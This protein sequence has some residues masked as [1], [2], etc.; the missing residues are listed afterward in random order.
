MNTHRPSRT[1]T[2]CL[3]VSLL[4]ILLLGCRDGDGGDTAAWEIATVATEG[5]VGEYCSVAVDGEGNA[6]VVYFDHTEDEQ[7]GTDTVPYGN[8][9]YASDVGGAWEAVTLDTGTGLTP[10]VIVGDD[11]VVHVVHT[12]LGVSDL[13]TLLDLKY[14]TNKSG[15]WGTIRISSQVAKGDDAGIAVD[16]GGGVHVSYRNEE[17]VGTSAEG[18]PGGLGYATNATGAWSRVIVDP[19]STAGNDTDVAIDGAGNVHISYLD[20]SGGMKYATNE[21]GSWEVTVIDDGA[22]VGWNSS[23]AVDGDGAVHISYSDP[24]PVLDP[25]GNGLLKYATNASGG[26]AVEVVDD[27]STG[28]YTGLAIDGQDVVH[29]AYYVWNGE[30][31]KLRYARGS[32]GSWEIETIDENESGAVG[33][34]SAIALAPDGKVVISYY[35]FTNQDLKVATRSP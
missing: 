5:N 19:S 25:P 8:L 29:I 3:L 32:A 23:I 35:D 31:G 21:S 28:F 30:V 34:F 18:S 22:H 27:E 12:A 16:A 6:H 24:S 14:T 13:A 26:W 11:D 2:V 33:L 4:A 15:T 17:G 7:I 10:R 9:G 20:K 1:T